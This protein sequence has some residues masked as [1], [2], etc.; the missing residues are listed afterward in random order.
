MTRTPAFPKGLVLG[1][2]PL[3]PRLGRARRYDLTPAGREAQESK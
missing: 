2:A 3:V 1:H